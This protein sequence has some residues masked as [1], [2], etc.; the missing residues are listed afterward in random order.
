[1]VESSSQPK[2]AIE[3]ITSLKALIARVAWCFAGPVT[4][5]FL[6]YKIAFSKDGWVTPSDI[7]FPI[8]LASTV[9]A[10]WISFRCGDRSNTIGE[11]TTLDELR[12]YSVIF[13]SVGLLG[14]AQ[15]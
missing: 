6:T 13:I 4:L 2:A 3:P 1:M 15:Q 5:A 11:V 7:A 12:R 10:R 9:A 14:R 8:I